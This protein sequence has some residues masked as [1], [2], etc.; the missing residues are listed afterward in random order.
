MSGTFT[1][2]IKKEDRADYHGDGRPGAETFG[3]NSPMGK[4]ALGRVDVGKACGVVPG[5]IVFGMCVD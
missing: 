1:R 3:G 4:M 2:E 5:V